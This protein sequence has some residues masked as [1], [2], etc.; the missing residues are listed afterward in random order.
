MADLDEALHLQGD[1]G[2]TQRRTADPQLLGQH[3]LSGQ[4]GPGPQIGLVGVLA[5]A[6]GQH[7]VERSALDP[8]QR[9]RR[10]DRLLVLHHCH[11]QLHFLH[12]R[13]S[14]RTIAP[15]TADLHVPAP[16]TGS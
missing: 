6:L 8:A 1:D 5:D 11:L 10:G 12:R 9:P 15:F 7:L 14:S 2:L 16:H 4:L 3:P 13:P